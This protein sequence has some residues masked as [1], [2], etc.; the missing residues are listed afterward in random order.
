MKAMNQTELA[1]FFG[2]VQEEYEANQKMIGEME[3]Q[4]AKLQKTLYRLNIHRQA[5]EE[6][7]VPNYAP[8]LPFSS[9]GK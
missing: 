3:A 8:W 5:L 9:N 7:Q 6:R 2:Q 1:K 4:Q